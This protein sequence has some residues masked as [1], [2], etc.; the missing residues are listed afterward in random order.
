V[1]AARLLAELRPPGCLLLRAHFRSGRPTCAGASFKFQPPK[2]LVGREVANG[3]RRLV[4]AQNR[5][6]S[7]SKR[8]GRLGDVLRPN[9]RR[10]S[11]GSGGGSGSG[12]GGP[13]WQSIR[14]DKNN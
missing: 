5:A 3:A 14:R 11:D 2:R 8:L 7:P 9:L 12:S 13:N 10:V 1:S 4:S 6:R